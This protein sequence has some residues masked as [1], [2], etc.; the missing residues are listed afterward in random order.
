LGDPPV[1]VDIDDGIDEAIPEVETDSFSVFAALAL[2]MEA[3]WTGARLGFGDVRDEPAVRGELER[4]FVRAALPQR[5]YVLRHLYIWQSPDMICIDS[6][7]WNGFVYFAARTSA[8][9]DRLDP[10]VREPLDWP[11]PNR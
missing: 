9:V 5:H 1:R 2:F 4:N 6:I 8:A 7:E 11:E 3:M 10:R